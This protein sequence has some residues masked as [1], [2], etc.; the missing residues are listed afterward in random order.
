MITIDVG[1]DYEMELKGKID[2]IEFRNRFLKEFDNKEIWTTTYSIILDFSGVLR[3]DSSFVQEAFAYFLK[4]EK[5]EIILEKIQ[6]FNISKAKKSV[7]D[8]ELEKGYKE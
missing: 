3:L 7:I 6:L 4:Y 5:P 8:T 1:N 2:G